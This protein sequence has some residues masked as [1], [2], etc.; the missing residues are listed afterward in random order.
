MTQATATALGIEIA[1]AADEATLV[2]GCST[3]RPAVV[4]FFNAAGP[5]GGDQLTTFV[6]QAK[7]DS[8]PT[9]WRIV[10]PRIMFDTDTP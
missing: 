7:E 6:S 3:P 8:L 1:T 5:D 2:F 9:G 10:K 4:T